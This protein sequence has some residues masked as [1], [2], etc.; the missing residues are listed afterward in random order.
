MNE[1]N[2]E[3]DYQVK[4]Q[5]DRYYKMKE[6]SHRLNEPNKILLGQIEDTMANLPDNSNIK[7]MINANLEEH[8]RAF[9]TGINNTAELPMV[10]K[11]MLPTV[12]KEQK[13]FTRAG[14]INAAILL[15]GMVNIGIIVAIAIMK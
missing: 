12:Q 9:N 15:Y 6:E 8:D 1:N 5:M 7:K 14:F 11:R 10:R 2:N 13:L 3:L 4:K